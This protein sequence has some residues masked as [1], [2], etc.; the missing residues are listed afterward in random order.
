MIESSNHCINKDPIEIL[1]EIFGYNQFKGQQEDIINNVI[2]KN[3]SFVLMP[4]GGGKSLCYQIP[5]L[6]LP[7]L[8]IV[9][10]PLIAL[11]Q[12]Q[13]QALQQY[14]VSVETIN[15]N[16][17]R[18][19][20]FQIKKMIQDN[21][22]KIL[23]VAPERLLMEEFLDLLSDVKISLF[24]ID[25]AHCVS[26]WGH[27][28][29]PVYTN[30]AILA[31]K[32][33]DTPR[34]A[35]TATADET[36]RKDIIDK[37]RLQDAKIF[38]DSFD[39]PN[40]NYAI[41]IA[42]N[43]K[44]QL[45]SFI[46]NNHQN[47]S[48]VIYCVSRKKTDEMTQFLKKEGFNALSYHAGMD[49]FQRAENQKQFQQQENIIMVA[50]IAFGMGIDKPDVRFVIH[51][52][53]P[54]NIESYYQETGRAGRD[55]LPS[56]ALMFYGLSDIAIQRN[57]IENSEAPEKQKRIERQKLNYLLGLCE[58][59]RCR[60]QIL[61]EYFGDSC[62]PCNNCDTCINKPETFDATIISQQALSCVYRTGQ[63]FGI[64]YLIDV[65]IGADNQR[66]KNFNHDKLQVFAIGK[67]Y[68]KQEWQSVFRQLV[69]QNLLKVDMVGHG[70]IK[71]TKQGFE[72]LKEKRT[73]ELGKY[74][75]IKTSKEKLKSNKTD[76]EKIKIDLEL[77]TDQEN[78]LFK[79][80]K[81]KRLEIAKEQN[82]PP[83]VIFHDKS[84]IEMVKIKPQSLD[85][86]L[87]ISGVGQAKID[88]YGQVFLD[89]I[90]TT[91]VLS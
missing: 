55:G 9:I 83:Y 72:F 59:T 22:L 82:L 84:L 35:L 86:M 87:D 56:N 31:D 66:I 25:E 26:Q 12:D 61:L 64:A 79:I 2:S 34:I 48:G 89:I 80:L 62:E 37:L 74:V 85:Q 10:S 71:I 49:S 15:S 3:N 8:A 7:G 28:F 39:R 70:G 44:K 20:V 24:A 5:S 41:T 19:K 17:S 4:T 27:D 53:V 45:I 14:G 58:A 52:N 16:I 68:S 29:R 90:L 69:A 33:P 91:V 60:R 1:K 65:L 21:A 6:H 38:I 63:I 57:F 75:K 36:T 11:M 42:N 50:T 43:P 40:I 13:V 47:Q 30:L 73:I 46:K 18:S 23:Y 88:R 78:D 54:K 51:M 81:E 67:E 77:N 32:F 76:K